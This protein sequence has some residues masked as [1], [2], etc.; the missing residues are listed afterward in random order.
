MGSEA[1]VSLA[2]GMCQPLLTLSSRQPSGA[3]SDSQDHHACTS[4][5]SG[6][7]RDFLEE[8]GLHFR[9]TKY[10][11]LNPTEFKEKHAI[12]RT[13]CAKT[14]NARIEKGHVTPA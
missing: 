2:E 1:A 13:S 3:S 12:T 14:R 8:I 10:K 9:E 4:F 11:H 7:T 5:T 6:I